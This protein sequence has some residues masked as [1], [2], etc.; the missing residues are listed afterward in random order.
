MTF[1]ARALHNISYSL[2]ATDRAAVL[3]GYLSGSFI[4]TDLAPYVEMVFNTDGTWLLYGSDSGFL[5][6]QSNTWLTGT[7]T[8]SDYYV[9]A[10]LVDTGNDGVLSGSPTQTWL[11]LASPQSWRV[12]QSNSYSPA[13]PFG[14][15]GLIYINYVPS[16]SPVPLTN[17]YLEISVGKLPNFAPG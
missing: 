2:P 7:G 10:D 14:A 1:M 5:S 17:G 15:Y 11:S 4:N 8:S 6:P 9:Y 3:P 16:F 13:D 12:T